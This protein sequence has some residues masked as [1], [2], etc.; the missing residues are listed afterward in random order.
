MAITNAKI[1]TSSAAIYTSSGANAITT[2]I[3]CNR[4]VFDPLNPTDNTAKLSLY[5]VPNGGSA[6]SPAIETII[7]NEL[8][9][10][11]GETVSFDQEKMVLAN[12]DMLVAISNVGTTGNPTLVAT[13]ST[14]AV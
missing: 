10:P 9:V 3:V 14:L 2:V 5:A 6:T 8:V 4:K 1:T 7:V 13:V 11:A 12:G